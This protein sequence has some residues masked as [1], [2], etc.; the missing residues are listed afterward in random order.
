MVAPFIDRRTDMIAHFTRLTFSRFALAAAFLTLSG[1]SVPAGSPTVPV[2]G[3]E[4]RLVRGEAKDGV[5]DVGL[6]IDLRPGWKTYWRAPGDA[7]IPP[8]FDSS[9]STGVAEVRPR[10]PAPVR[11]DEAGLVGVGYVA[12]VIV[13]L[14]VRLVD[15]AGP[16]DLRLTVHIGLCQDMCVPL[17]AGLSL[18]I[19]PAAVVDPEVAGRL[20]AARARVPVAATAE[21]LPRIVTLSRDDAATPQVVTVE[22]AMPADAPATERDVFVEGPSEAW[23]LPVPEPIGSE[24]GRARWRFALDGSPANTDMTTARLRFTLRGGMRAVEQTVGLDGTGVLP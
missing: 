20:A 8:S 6:E 7:G 12:P 2:S 9:G 15:P 14:D 11:F 21:G 24:G 10:F 23:S 17:E 1:A 5:V 19:D 22:V 13:P 4:I 18:R 3:A 16:A